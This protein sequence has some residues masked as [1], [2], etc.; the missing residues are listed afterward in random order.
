PEHRQD[1]DQHDRGGPEPEHEAG[2][3]ARAKRLEQRSAEEQRDAADDPRADHERRGQIE[4][5][6]ERPLLQPGRE[7]REPE[8]EREGADEPD[9]HA[10]EAILS[11]V[12]PSYS[13]GDDYEIQYLHY[14]FSFNA[15]DFEQRVT[16]AAVKLGLVADNELDADEASDL[17]ELVERDHIE[18]PR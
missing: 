7:G 1:G 16:A 18:D 8:R 13:S 6:L 2:V 14:R 5:P 11:R 9:G 12:E 15:Q 3:P 4:S 10:A 17:V